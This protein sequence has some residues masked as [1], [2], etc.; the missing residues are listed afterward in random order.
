MIASADPAVI[1]RLLPMHAIL[2]PSGEVIGCGLTMRKVIGDA[3]RLDRI[4]RL[5][6]PRIDGTGL[7]AM[8]AAIR[9]AAQSGARILLALNTPEGLV[10]R[11]HGM[12]LD[13]GRILV[14]FGFGT[15]LVRAVEHFSLTDADFAPDDLATEFLFL[16]QASRALL[17]GLSGAN[18]RLDQARQK[19]EL[20]AFTDPL[21]GVSNR[22]GLEL[23]MA[24]AMTQ[25]TTGKGEGF[26][27]AHL[28]LDHFKAVN[29]R[30]GHQAGDE[31]LCHVAEILRNATRMQ[32]VVARLGGDEFVLILPGV[33]RYAVL[34]A[35]FSR[36]IAEIEAPIPTHAGIAHITASIG[37]TLSAFHPTGSV[38]AM[39]RAA[40][41]ALYAAKH[42]GRG[43]WR[44]A[45]GKDS[46]QR[47]DNEG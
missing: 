37:V 34:D 46:D 19:A 14:N 10:L 21:T 20:Q 29:D 12:L 4:G 8:M 44:L 1:T 15:G 33:G 9:A 23:A 41:T 43:C 39:H 30:L 40:D 2:G 35:L 3:T 7:P 36:L 17:G 28:D 42:I 24:R 18:L 25:L 6:R 26:A 22:R 31:V 38:P 13:D 47:P 27:L 45:P 16:H 5:D 11:G 32:D